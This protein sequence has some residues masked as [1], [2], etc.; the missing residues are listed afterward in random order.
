MSKTKQNI[1]ENILDEYQETQSIIDVQPFGGG[2]IN[3]TFL[4]ETPTDKYILQ[5]VNKNVFRTEALVK[6][7]ELF[8]KSIFQYQADNK[9]KITPDILKTKSGA[10]HIID[11]DGYAWRLAEFIPGT[12]AYAISPSKEISFKAAEAVGKFQLFLNTLP[13][14]QFDYTILHFHDPER[15]LKA[16]QKALDTAKPNLLDQ[17]KEETAFC[18]K[19][20][21]IVDEYNKIKDHLPEKVTHNDT[22]L[23]N[24]LFYD[25][26]KTLVIDLDTVM[27]STILFDYGDMVRT[28]TSPVAEDEK[29][30]S[31][32]QFRRD[33]FEALTHG[34]LS[35]L[36]GDL[37]TIEKDHL[38]LGAKT[39]IYEQVLR[40]LTDY[41]LGNPYYKVKYPEHNLVRTKTQV[42]LLD[43]ILRNSEQLESFIRTL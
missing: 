40:F 1:P 4:V 28:F 32:V 29:E 37:Q 12:T 7:Y 17:A 35:G 21:N 18:L 13:A 8:L 39:I 15:R 24:I 42:K 33:H 36:N 43:T 41:L 3:D 14:H 23:D 27:P 30:S 22:K 25:Q 10:F 19:F 16:F 20:S 2:H 31:K 9:I 11:N 34:Y 38:L 6:N 5:R 26:G